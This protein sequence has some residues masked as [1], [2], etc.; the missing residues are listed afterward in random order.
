[1]KDFVKIRNVS[2]NRHYKSKFYSSLIELFNAG[3][4][5]DDLAAPVRWGTVLLHAG[6]ETELRG[7][8]QHTPQLASVFTLC[9][10]SAVNI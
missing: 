10:I 5:S 9:Q 6:E 3:K 8:L 4:S 2:C 1:M 7:D